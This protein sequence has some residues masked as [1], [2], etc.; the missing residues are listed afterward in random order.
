MTI[1]DWRSEIDEV[2]CQLLRLL[3]RRARLAVKV[4]AVKRAANL[5]LF[6]PDREQE[7]LKRAGDQNVGPL[8]DQAIAKIFRRIIYE[9]RRAETLSYESASADLQEVS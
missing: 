9:S 3:N 8:D 1:E 6:D 4:G 5:P 2:D 7:V